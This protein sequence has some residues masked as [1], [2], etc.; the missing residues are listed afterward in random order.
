MSAR[1]P[2]CCVT[3]VGERASLPTCEFH[4]FGLQSTRLDDIGMHLTFVAP[5]SHC[6]SP[7]NSA[8]WLPE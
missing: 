1:A 3:D 2:A 8:R 4:R 6:R 7:I 5:T